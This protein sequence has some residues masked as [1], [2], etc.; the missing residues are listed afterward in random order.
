MIS[1]EH[2]PRPLEEDPYPDVQGV[3]LS[4]EIIRY[5]RSHDLISP[6]DRDNLRP[7]S[8]NLTLGKRFSKNGVFDT[9]D[10]H[11]PELQI[12]PHEAVLVQTEESL[13]LPRYLIGRWSPRQS[14]IFD[15]LVY[16]TG[17]HIDPGW[18]GNLWVPIYNLSKKIIRLR[19]GEPFGS[20]DFTKTTSFTENVSLKH[21]KG[22]VNASH[23]GSGLEEVR[24]N[25]GKFE[26]QLLSYQR[27]LDNYQSS[28]LTVLV[29]II[30]AVTII[31]ASPFL[32]TPPLLPFPDLTVTYLQLFIGI[33]LASFVVSLLSL[34]YSRLHLRRRQSELNNR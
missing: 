34:N 5:V 10:E 20:I 12:H 13:R 18:E 30:A 24:D 3:L 32:R 25:V 33:S 28:M 26:G 23:P 17:V 9:L 2:L 19:L 21:V 29:I 15:G 16:I 8:Y 31:A 4:D 22:W 6:Y 14:K 7:A 11:H 1:P 27:R